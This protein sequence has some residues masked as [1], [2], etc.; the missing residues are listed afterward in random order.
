MPKAQQLFVAGEYAHVG[1]ADAHADTQCV[2]AGRV[3]AAERWGE[4]PFGLF[5]G[6]GS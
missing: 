1:A 4:R 2:Q 6:E 3:R 5:R